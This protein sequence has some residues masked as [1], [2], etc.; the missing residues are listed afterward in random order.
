MTQSVG[1]VAPQKSALAPVILLHPDDNILVCVKH[2][3]VGDVVAIDGEF[4][5]SA[6]AI[7][8]GHKIARAALSAGDKVYRYGAPIGSMIET[9]AKGEHVHMHNMKSDY[10]PSHTRNR[11]NKDRSES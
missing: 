9:V 2:I 7:D 3:S 4:I 10:I 1:S 6:I 8:V 11:Q 5:T